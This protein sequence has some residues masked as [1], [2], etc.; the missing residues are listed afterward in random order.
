MC[1]QARISAHR[2][3]ILCL[4]D[5]TIRR[6]IH[7]NGNWD[8]VVVPSHW[9]TYVIYKY[10]YH[11]FYS[12][13]P[14]DCQYDGR[15]EMG[16][17]LIIFL[18]CFSPFCMLQLRNWKSQHTH[19]Q[20]CHDQSTRSLRWFCPRH[21]FLLLLLLFLCFVTHFQRLRIR[22]FANSDF[23]FEYKVE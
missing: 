23:D 3:Q 21:I 8:R 11:I 17:Q 7:T 9:I 16:W 1:R 6:N 10:K 18:H 15:H 19:A 12:L 22:S 5:G 14:T 13:H 2:M 20:A 4:Y